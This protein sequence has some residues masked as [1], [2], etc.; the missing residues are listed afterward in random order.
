MP[1]RSPNHQLHYIATVLDFISLGH[2]RSQWPQNLNSN[3]NC[4]IGHSRGLFVG[5]YINRCQQPKESQET[6]ETTSHSSLRWPF[7]CY[8][9]GGVVDDVNSV[10]ILKNFQQ[11]LDNIILSFWLLSFR[12]II[13][14]IIY[15]AKIMWIF[16]NL[17][18][19]LS[20]CLM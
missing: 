9:G 14:W 11:D 12:R 17:S 16:N 10:R 5:I 13:L 8:Y 6:L 1:K 15:A 19:L 7:I 2:L 18:N 3:L 4:F 20:F